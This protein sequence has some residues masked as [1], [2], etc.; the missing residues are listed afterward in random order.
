VHVDV[1]NDGHDAMS[2][3]NPSLPYFHWV[4]K[5]SDKSVEHT[6]VN[7]AVLFTDTAKLFGRVTNFPFTDQHTAETHQQFI[8]QPITLIQP[9]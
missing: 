2:T 8:N 3:E 6:H 5:G 1:V 7:I 4:S 9:M